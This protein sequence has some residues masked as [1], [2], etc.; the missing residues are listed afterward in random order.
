MPK[1]ACL[2][3]TY[4]PDIDDLRERPALYIVK[5]LIKEGYDILLV[6][7]NV[8][9]FKEFKIYKIN[10]ALEKADLIVF[11][12]KHKTFLNIKIK[13]KYFLDFCGMYA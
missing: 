3:L 6:D 10:E 8:K 9:D 4:K 11:L 13:N 12:V 2:G 7:P 1:I 5:R